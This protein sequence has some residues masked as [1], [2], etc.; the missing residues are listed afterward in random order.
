MVKLCDDAIHCGCSDL[1]KLSQK[2]KERIAE[3]LQ[4]DSDRLE[5]LSLAEVFPMKT[6]EGW[7]LSGDGATCWTKTFGSFR[8]AIDEAMK[9]EA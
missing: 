7:C 3:R 5:W 9:N 6:K 8:D 4:K 1:F 2:E